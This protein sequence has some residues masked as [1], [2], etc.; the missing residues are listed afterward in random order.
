MDAKRISA[1]L[2]ALGAGLAFSL[3]AARGLDLPDPFGLFGDKK[4]E[5]APG[6]PP[7]PPASGSL[8]VDCP[9]ILV[10]SGAASLRS[11]PG[12]D[13]AAVRYQLSL[14]DMA[15][16]CAMQGDRIAIKV[17]VEGAA[18]LGPAGSPGAYSGALRISVRRQKD[19]SIADSK[20]YRV[21][22]TIPSGATRGAFRVIADPLLVPYVGP[23]AADEY[24][25]LVGFEGG[26]AETGAAERRRHGRRGAAR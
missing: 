17:G 4:A 7:A 15:R 14:G 24:E 22:A 25:I 13:N 11:P 18:V 19:E 16:E 8:G 10:D 23:Q 2:A 5:Q 20:T 3:G 26:V 21:S 12:A 9:E 1:S 6:A